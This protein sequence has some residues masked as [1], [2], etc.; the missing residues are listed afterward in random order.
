MDSGVLSDVVVQ[1]G[2]AGLAAVLLV[3]LWWTIRRVLDLLA[4]CSR[5]IAHN[6]AA[7]EGLEAKLVESLRLDIDLRDRLLARPCLLE[8]SARTPRPAGFD[9]HRAA[10]L[11]PDIRRELARHL[12]PSAGKG[13]GEAPRPSGADAS[14]SDKETPR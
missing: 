6:T 13:L 10:G 1:N 14:A 3:A 5:V 2:F 8:R 12:E 9:P 4:E 7:L 11:D